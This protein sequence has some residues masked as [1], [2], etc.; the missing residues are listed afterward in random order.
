MLCKH[1]MTGI[2]ILVSKK[3]Q[4]LALLLDEQKKKG[5]FPQLHTLERA[6]L[7]VSKVHRV[8]RS[9]P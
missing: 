6:S 1:F 3:S 7:L 5:G 9:G 2:K 8:F 4:M